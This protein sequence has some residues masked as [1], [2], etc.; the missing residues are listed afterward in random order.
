M[1]ESSLPL[2]AANADRTKVSSA[3]ALSLP[4][5]QPGSAP[6]P[7]GMRPVTCAAAAVDVP[8]PPRPKETQRHLALTQ[9][10]KSQEQ[11]CLLVRAIAPKSRRGRARALTSRRD[12]RKWSGRSLA[13]SFATAWVPYRPRQQ[14]SPSSLLPLCLCNSLPRRPWPHPL[15]QHEVIAT[16]SRRA[17]QSTS[18]TD[19]LMRPPLP[20]PT[21]LTESSGSLWGKKTETAISGR[22][23]PKK[24][25]GIAVS[26]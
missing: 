13:I 25:A 17:R 6:N 11:S 24:R 12:R 21:Q 7:T 5:P 20:L 19:W 14:R 23:P 22:D 9:L 1:K 15:L 16:Q 26:H 2:Q 8:L 4:P 18:G 3:Q 10:K